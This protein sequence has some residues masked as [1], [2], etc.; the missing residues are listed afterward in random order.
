LGEHQS[1]LDH[2]NFAVILST[3]TDTDTIRDGLAV[4]GRPDKYADDQALASEPE[5]P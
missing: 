5:L 2:G 3:D 1:D 4:L